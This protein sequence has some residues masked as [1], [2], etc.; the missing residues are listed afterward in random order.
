MAAGAKGARN[1]MGMLDGKV[2]A[3]AVNHPTRCVAMELGESNVRVNSVSPGAIAISILPKALGMEAANADQAIDKVTA[4]YA[5]AQPLPRA[6]VPDDIA[7][8][9]LW[10]AADRS[11]FVNGA[12]IVVDGGAIRGRNYSAHQEGLRRFRDTLGM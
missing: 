3:A 7:Q 2:G 12:D 10:L 8:C 1:R 4:L 5:K 11:A 6:G 9:V